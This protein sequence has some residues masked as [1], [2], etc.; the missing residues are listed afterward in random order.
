M[1]TSVGMGVVGDG[2]GACVVAGVGGREG[3]AVG[4]SQSDTVKTPDKQPSART[5]TEGSSS[6]SGVSGGKDSTQGDDT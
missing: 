2:V 6:E 3:A 5:S 1:I 4:A